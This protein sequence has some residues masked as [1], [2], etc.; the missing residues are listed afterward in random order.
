[1]RSNKVILNLELPKE[2]T[3]SLDPITLPAV[4]TPS[5]DPITL[6]TVLTPSVEFSI[7]HHY[8]IFCKLKPVSLLY[9]ADLDP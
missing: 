5:L 2:L 1:M 6:P 4:L 7:L 3:P 8:L 9:I